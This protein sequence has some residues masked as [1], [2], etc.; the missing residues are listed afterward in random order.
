MS[1]MARACRRGRICQPRV[2]RRMRAHRC[3][4]RPDLQRS[5]SALWTRMR[6]VRRG[7]RAERKQDEVGQVDRR[8]DPPQRQGSLPAWFQRRPTLLEDDAEAV[9]QGA[10]EVGCYGS[11]SGRLVAG[12]VEEVLGARNGLRWAPVPSRLRKTR[13]EKLDLTRTRFSKAISL[14]NLIVHLVYTFLCHY[15]QLNINQWLMYNIYLYPVTSLIAS[16][17]WRKRC[18]MI[19][20]RSIFLLLIGTT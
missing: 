12:E 17:E 5:R 16:S 20:L 6:I 19:T 13:R 15:I 7:R 4:R 2:T 3:R 10:V 11:H 9:F 1:W 14:I 8:R 18:N